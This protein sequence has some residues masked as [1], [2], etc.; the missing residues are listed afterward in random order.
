MKTA[1]KLRKSIMFFV[2]LLIVI[3]AT[4]GFAEIWNVNYIESIFSNKGNYVVL[5]SYVL[6]FFTFA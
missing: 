5:L 1:V 2:K 4:T 6:I 3:V